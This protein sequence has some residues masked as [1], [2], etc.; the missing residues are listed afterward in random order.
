MCTVQSL[1]LVCM[2]SCGHGVYLYHRS[3]LEVLLWY[4]QIQG[5]K[6]TYATQKIECA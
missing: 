3:C 6:Y 4:A 5:L 2:F 1:Y